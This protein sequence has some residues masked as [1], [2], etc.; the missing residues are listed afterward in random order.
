MIRV[1]HERKDP[2]F[3]KIKYG[4]KLCAAGLSISLIVSTVLT[5][6]EL[7]GKSHR[8]NVYV[9]PAST[10][11]ASTEEP[12]VIGMSDEDAFIGVSGPDDGRGKGGAVVYSESGADR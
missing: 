2:W 9:P 3:Q 11:A 8:N 10:D 5:G 4:K 1:E 6:C 7:P 12:D